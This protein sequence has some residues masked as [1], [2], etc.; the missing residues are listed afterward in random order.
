MPMEGNNSTN[1][2]TR[3]SSFLFELPRPK[4]TFL[5]VVFSI[6]SITATLFNLLV[7]FVYFRTKRLSKPY[8]KILLS[9]AMIDFLRGL[10]AAPVCIFIMFQTNTCL[11]RKLRLFNIFL[12]SVSCFVLCSISYD[13]Y[14]FVN[15]QI[16][17]ANLMRGWR[18]RLT[19]GLPWLLSLLIMAGF[20]LPTR[21]RNWIS[22]GQFGYIFYIACY[23]LIYKKLRKRI[24]SWKNS[25]HGS[26]TKIIIKDT[27][28]SL[29]LILLLT[30]CNFV[31]TTPFF[32]ERYLILLDQYSILN[33]KQLD[34]ESVLRLT[35][36]S[37][38][39][40]KSSINPIIYFAVSK[41]FFPALLGQIHPAQESRSSRFDSDAQIVSYNRHYV[42]IM[43]H[44]EHC[45]ES[46]PRE[47]NLK[48]KR[49][50]NSRK[51]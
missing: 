43:K 19:I 37:F 33:L 13:R 1:N 41:D 28:R 32:I 12:L 4:K 29:R 46:S 40:L 17:Y 21:I 49:N 51:N 42:S 11:T 27:Q 35:V 45:Q 9:L 23:I 20:L 7:L 25:D 16:E 10:I 22:I 6:I 15:K 44:S 47:S 18:F 39:F 38:M 31:C 34:P 3:C 8:N 26:H 30:F 24:R 50:I 2:N 48:T 36:M 5:V 14:L